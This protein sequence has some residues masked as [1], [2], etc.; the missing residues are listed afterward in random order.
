MPRVEG[1]KQSVVDL[2]EDVKRKR[3]KDGINQIV[4]SQQIGIGIATL[5]FLEQGAKASEYT[6]EKVK[7]WLKT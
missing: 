6:I 7:Q 4:A 3:R 5:R 1:L 2:A